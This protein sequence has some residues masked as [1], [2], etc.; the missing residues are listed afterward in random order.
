[1]GGDAFTRTRGW[2]C[3]EKCPIKINTQTAAKPT[4]TRRDDQMTSRHQP[5]AA[6]DTGMRLTVLGLAA[7]R[8]DSAQ[9][10]LASGRGWSG[11]WLSAQPASVAAVPWSSVKYFWQGAQAAK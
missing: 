8:R 9:C 6:A 7:R 2:S 3:S 10:S 11:G 1:M 4:Q 5:P